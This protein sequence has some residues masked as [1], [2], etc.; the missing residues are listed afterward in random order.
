MF[1]N[2]QGCCIGSKAAQ[3]SGFY[4]ETIKHVTDKKNVTK[5][6]LA[7]TEEFIETFLECGRMVGTTK[8]QQSSL[9]VD[10]VMANMTSE[11]LE[12]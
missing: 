11:S 10:I 3:P 8:I 1:K 9:A 6:T 4:L 5:S 2:E 12:F 7:A